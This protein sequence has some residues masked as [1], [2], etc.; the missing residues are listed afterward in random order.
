VRRLAAYVVSLNPQ[1]PGPVWLLEAGFFV[2]A[3]GTGV[4]YPFLVIYLHNVR[5]FS[6]ATAGL[7]IAFSGLAGLAS[8]PLFGRV[9]D[10]VF[11]FG[12]VL[13]GFCVGL[14]WSFD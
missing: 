7:E 10:R 2:N 5:G 14:F 6:L 1:L 4:A 3:F 11:F 8:G 9:V 13:G 12:V